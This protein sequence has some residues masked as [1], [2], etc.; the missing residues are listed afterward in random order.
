ML[1]FEAP[2]RPMQDQACGYSSMGGGNGHTWPPL[3]AEERLMAALVRVSFFKGC[4]PW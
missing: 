3:L 2:I 4:G 1:I